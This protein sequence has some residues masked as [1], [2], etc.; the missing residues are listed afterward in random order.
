MFQQQTNASLVA[1]YRAMQRN[2]Y[3]ALR[4]ELKKPSF[5][6]N[7]WSTQA[8][9]LPEKITLHSNFTP[10]AYAMAFENVALVE[11]FLLMGANAYGVHSDLN[12]IYLINKEGDPKKQAQIEQLFLQYQHPGH[13]VDSPLKVVRPKIYF[14]GPFID[15]IKQGDH[16]TVSRMLSEGF[17]YTDQCCHDVF[18]TALALAVESRSFDT[19]AL[20]VER[21][22]AISNDEVRRLLE[23]H[24]V[25]VSRNCLN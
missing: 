7:H 2:D 14:D 17:I 10:M 21:G 1:I 4:D 23:T 6:I 12:P 13:A 19:V 16:D 5:D 18:S 22:A 3:Y 20:L 9:D 25:N 11:L 15:A 24:G 8:I